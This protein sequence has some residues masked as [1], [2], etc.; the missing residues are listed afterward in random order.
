MSSPVALRRSNMDPARRF[1]KRVNTTYC[2][3]VLG[4]TQD[5][6]PRAGR[7]EAIFRRPPVVHRQGDGRFYCLPAGCGK[8]E[9]VTQKSKRNATSG[10]S[11]NAQEM[12][13]GLI[14]MR[15]E[16]RLRV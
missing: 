7:R 10:I 11:E 5:V 9:V 2:A 1:V 16:R 6:P 14:G 4:Q 12:R 3:Y 13:C 8:T 15:T